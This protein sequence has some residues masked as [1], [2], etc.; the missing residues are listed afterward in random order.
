MTPF[1]TYRE[2]N[3]SP[4]PPPTNAY[5]L[6]IMEIMLEILYL[7]IHQELN[8]PVKKTET[9]RGSQDIVSDDDL[10]PVVE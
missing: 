2:I 9:L 3:D 1:Y 10:Q 4:P 5:S 6:I 8:S 7:D